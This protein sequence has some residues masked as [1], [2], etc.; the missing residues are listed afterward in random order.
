MQAIGSIIVD[1]RKVKGCINIDFRQDDLDKDQFYLRFNWQNGE[2]VKTLFTSK[3]FDFFQ[4]ALQ[5]LCKPP[6]VEIEGGEKSAKINTEKTQKVS[7]SKQIIDQLV[8]L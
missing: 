5:V 2:S 7:L 6:A 4:G 1:L 3:E 8:A